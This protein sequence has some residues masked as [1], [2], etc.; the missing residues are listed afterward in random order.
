MDPHLY[1]VFV[2][3]GEMFFTG[4]AFV[5]DPVVVG[6][7]FVEFYHDLVAVDFSH[8]TGGRGAEAFRVPVSYCFLPDVGLNV[9]AP[10]YDEKVRSDVF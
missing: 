1:P 5:V 7:V 2:N 3:T 8:D 4:V 6:E 9:A 10:V